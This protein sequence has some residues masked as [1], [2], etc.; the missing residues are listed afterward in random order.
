MKA[1]LWYHFVKNL[2]WVYFRLFHDLRVQGLENIPAG[3][4]LLAANHE[5]F[6]DPPLIGCALDQDLYFLARKTL[7]DPPVMAW[8]LPSIQALPIDQER[9]DM[10]GLK[11]IIALLKQGERVALFPEGART[12]DG[13]LQPA[14]PGV[15]LVVAKVEVPVVP[16]RIFGGFK[17]WPRGGRPRWFTPLRVVYGAPIRFAVEQR[18]G[19][20]AYQSL[21]DRIMEA[22]AELGW[23]G[24]N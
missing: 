24:D 5:S 6:F 4:F 19:K 21:G 9:P 20:D 2:C 10:T 22:I 7:F 3:G 8:L 14:A 18:R 13:R 23:E 1:K 16:C 15:G 17:A 12:L 11:R